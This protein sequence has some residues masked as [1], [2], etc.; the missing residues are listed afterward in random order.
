MNDLEE[1][2]E[3]YADG[4]FEDLGFTDLP[5]ERKA[6][7]FARVE[8]HLHNVIVDEL[9][10]D[11]D[12]VKMEVLKKAL[13]QQDY[14]VASGVLDMAE[15]KVVLENRIERELNQLKAVIKREQRYARD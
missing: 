13:S 10:R 14:K 9:S 3:E 8:E 4:L 12:A 6:E 11:L 7:I 15:K 2:I 5:E 1:K